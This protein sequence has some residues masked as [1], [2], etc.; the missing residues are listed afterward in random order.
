[1]VSIGTNS[2]ALRYTKNLQSHCPPLACRRTWW[3]AVPCF[4]NKSLSNNFNLPNHLQTFFFLLMPTKLV[5]T[6]Y[7]CLYSDWQHSLIRY[8]AA[9]LLLYSTHSWGQHLS[10][11]I[12][13]KKPQPTSLHLSFISLGLPMK[14]LACP[15]EAATIA[16]IPNTASPLI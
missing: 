7:I 10:T 5:K 13:D 15:C 8:A 16:H 2:Q 9:R 12:V 14:P 1:M 6:M 3:A 4:L 11:Q